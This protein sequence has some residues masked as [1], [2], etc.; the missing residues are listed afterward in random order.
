[1]EL[2]NTVLGSCNGKSC[3]KVGEDNLITLEYITPKYNDYN[4]WKVSITYEKNVNTNLTLKDKK[5]DLDFS[6]I[7]DKDLIEYL[8]QLKLDTNNE[9][10]YIDDDNVLNYEDVL[11]YVHYRKPTYEEMKESGN[12]NL[13]D[14]NIGEFI[15]TDDNEMDLV[16]LNEFKPNNILNEICF[17][18]LK[19]ILEKKEEIYSS[20]I[21]V[22]L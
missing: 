14:Y 22:I 20:K 12:Y 10:F 8:E 19:K 4:E 11:T 9:L 3:F 21:S 13:E 5:F 1:M 6:N 2:I 17:S 15:Y 16:L 18:Y 7:N